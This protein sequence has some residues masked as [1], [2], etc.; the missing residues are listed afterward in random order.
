MVR[1]QSHCPGQ[2]IGN[3]SVRGHRRGLLRRRS[4]V[5][6]ALLLCLLI[7]ALPLALQA[8]STA[9]LN[10]TVKKVFDGDSLLL[11]PGGGRRWVK[12]RFYGVD[13]PELEFKDRWGPQP[14][15][16][17]AREFTAR[18][19]L[20]ERVSVRLKGERNRGR[21]IGEVF[22]NGRSVSRELLRAGLAWWSR[23]HEPQDHDLKRLHA[24]A[25]AARIGIWS[26]DRPVPPWKHRS[27]H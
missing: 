26:L 9:F 21:E 8:A 14:K 20:G 23:K 2:P 25:R 24:A 6:A 17:E 5:A 22:V 15:S 19:V 18:M 4:A 16:D 11:D 13:C 7:V 3:G 10:G 12:I 1:Q 27:R